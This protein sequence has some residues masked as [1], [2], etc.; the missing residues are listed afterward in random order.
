MQASAF[1][2]KS[3]WVP[4][5]GKFWRKTRTEIRSSYSSRPHKLHHDHVSRITLIQ[6]LF[7]STT[8]KPANVIGPRGDCIRPRGEI[9]SPINAMNLESFGPSPGPNVASY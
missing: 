6:L 5:E 8:L 1:A 7:H 4:E 2:M 3:L 9:W